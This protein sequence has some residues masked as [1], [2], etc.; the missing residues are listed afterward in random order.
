MRTRRIFV[1][2][3]I[4]TASAGGV[5]SRAEAQPASY[6]DLVPV[7]GHS[8]PYWE[9]FCEDLDAAGQP[10]PSPRPTWGDLAGTHWE[11]HADGS[12]G[13]RYPDYQKVSNNLKLIQTLQFLLSVLTNLT[14]KVEDAQEQID[15]LDFDGLTGFA[16]VPQAPG[17]CVCLH[18]DDCDPGEVL[19]QVDQ[20]LDDLLDAHNL[21]AA[22]DDFLTAQVDATITDLEGLEDYFEQLLAP[23]AGLEQDLTAAFY[24]GV[25][26]EI[27]ALIAQ[28]KP[29]AAA[30]CDLD[31]F[32]NYP[33]ELSAA[34]EAA[35]LEVRTRVEADVQTLEAAIQTAVTLPTA[36][37]QKVEDDLGELKALF[38]GVDGKDDL[39][40]LDFA[41][42]KAKLESMAAD[43]RQEVENVQGQIDAVKA[44]WDNAS[45]YTDLAG[46]LR[47]AVR[48]QLDGT[49]VGPCL[50]VLD[51]PGN[52]TLPSA[53]NLVEIGERMQA[54]FL[55]V[56]EQ[57]VGEARQRVEDVLQRL[58][59]R[60][61]GAPKAALDSLEKAAAS[62][63]FAGVSG[64]YLRG[65]RPECFDFC[66]TGADGFLW[67]PVD[68][69][70]D[71]KAQVA[72]ALEAG[73][74][75][76]KQAGWLDGIK[77]WID[78]DD[79][80]SGFRAQVSGGL[81]TALGVVADLK[82]AIEA[83]QKVLGETLEYV[84]RFMEGTHLGGYSV[85]RPDLHMCVPYAGHGPYARLGNLG[86]DRFSVGA[87]YTSHN[88]SHR[89]RAAFRS[90]GFAASALGRELSLLPAVEL[91]TQIHGFRLWD[92]RRPLGIPL[93]GTID[94]AT[95]EKLDVFNVVPPGKASL[96][97]PDGKLPLGSAIVRDLHPSK[98][99]PLA[100]ADWP[101]ADID[102]PWEDESTAVVSLGLN[103]DFDLPPLEWRLPP[104]V[105]IPPSVLTATPRFGFAA[106][107]D[108]THQS[109]LFRDRIEGM[110]N[111]N[112]PQDVQLDAQDF[113]REMHAFQAPDLSTDDRNSVYVE[114]SVGIDAF[115][116]FRVWKVS[117]GAGASADLAVN[118][119][120]GGQGGVL[121]LNSALS[122]AVAASNPPPEAVC[123]PRWHFEE[124][125]L[126]SNR[127]F[128]E[129]TG[130]YACEPLQG[131][132]SC[133][134]AA[135]W[136]GGRERICIDDW[137]GIDRARCGDLNR[138]LDAESMR[139]ALGGVPGFLS[140]ASERLIALAEQHDGLGLATT[141]N[142]DAT[143]AS[144]PCGQPEPAISTAGLNVAALSECQA[145]GYCTEP[146]GRIVHDMTLGE[147]E[148]PARYRQVAVGDGRF[149]RACALRASGKLDCW[150]WDLEPPPGPFT[151]VSTSR[152]QVC[153]LRPDGR[154][155]CWG[156]L[157]AD[158]SP[159]AGS[160]LAVSAGDEFSC[161]IRSDQK[162]TCWGQEMGT[163]PPTGTFSQV[164]VFHGTACA[165]ATDRRVHCWG[166]VDQSGPLA[167]SGPA[168]AVDVTEWPGVAVLL[169]NGRIE[170]RTF[171]SAIPCDL[172]VLGTLG[173]GP[174]VEI[175]V[176]SYCGLCAR[177]D[178]GSVS[179]R[180]VM[181]DGLDAPAPEVNLSSIAALPD[182][183]ALCGI[184]GDGVVTCWNGSGPPEVA[185]ARFTSYACRTEI[186]ETLQGWQG[187]GCHPLQH[188]FPS[189]CACTE[190]SQCAAGETC[191]LES[192][193]CG[194]PAGAEIACLAAA[195]G[196]CPA[197][198]T[199]LDGACTTSCAGDAECAG[200]A[201]CDGGLCRP[202][203]GVPFAEQIVWGMDYVPV[204]RH[205]INTYA[206]SDFEA[207][208]LLKAGV[209]VEASFKL[210]G[211]A[212]RW[213]LLDFADAWDLGSTYKGWYQ[214]GLSARY[215]H[216]CGAP[217][218]PWQVTNHFPASPTAEPG[219]HSATNAQG[220]DPTR[221]CGPLQ[222]G[223][224]CRYPEPPA[225]D[226]DDVARL[227]RWCRD[228]LPQHA[229][230][231]QAPS[232][233]DIAGGVVL[234]VEWGQEVGLDLWAENQ[235]CVGGRTW[236]EWLEGLAPTY[237]ADGTVLDRGSLDG[238]QCVYDDPKSGDPYQFE[239]SEL[240]ERMLAI[241]GCTDVGAPGAVHVASRPGVTTSWDPVAGRTVLDLDSIFRPVPE[242][243]PLVDDGGFPYTWENVRPEVRTLFVRLWLERL[244]FCFDRRFEDPAEVECVCHLDADCD[245]QGG[246][247]CRQG[248]CERPRLYDQEGECLRPGCQPVWQARECPIVRLRLDAGPCCGDGVV[249]QTETYREECDPE[250]EAEAEAGAGAGCDSRCRSMEPRGAC[251]LV[252]GLCLEDTPASDC[253]GGFHPGLS[254]A[255]VASCRTAG[256]PVT[257]ACCDPLAGCR[258]GVEAAG[259]RRGI[260]SPGLLCS[261]LGGCDA[262]VTG[263][264]CEG[265]GR[266][267]DGVAP[268]G[269]TDGAFYPGRECHELDGCRSIIGAGCTPAPPGM[270]A[271]WSFDDGEAPAVLERRS[272]A[273]GETVNGA[274]TVLGR[275]GSA[276]SLDGVDDHVAVPDHP[277]LAVGEGDFSIDL[278]LAADRQPGVRPIVDKRRASR[279]GG[280]GDSQL[281][282][283]AGTP[284]DR[285]RLPSPV[286]LGS[287][288][289]FELYLYAGRPGLQ[290]ADGGHTNF[291]SGVAIADGR[292][293]HLTVTVDRDDLQGIRWYLDGRPAGKPGNPT[294]RTGSL[295][296]DAP[297][298]IGTERVSPNWMRGRVD[299]L[300]IF[301]RV[302][303]PA[304]VAAI[305]D[306][307][308]AGKCRCAPPPRGPLG[309]WSFEGGGDEVGRDRVRGWAGRLE[310]AVRPTPGVVGQA[311]S[312][313][314]GRLEL[315]VGSGPDVAAGDL[316]IDAWIRTRSASG[317]ILDRRVREGSRFRG[318]S[319]FVHQGR[320]GLQLADG[321]WTNYVSTLA[322]ADGEWHHVAVT[323]DRDQVD[324]IRW[325]LD[326]EP[327]GPRLDPR[328]RSGS[329]ANPGPLRLGGRSFEAAGGW[330][331]DIDELEVA[332]RVLGPTEAWRIRAAGAAGKCTCPNPF[333]PL[334]RYTSR[335]PRPCA[336]R[337]IACRLLEEPFND[338]CG[339]GCIAIDLDVGK[340]EEGERGDRIPTASPFRG[341][342][343]TTCP[344]MVRPA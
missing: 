266:C 116:G 329:L 76:L 182:S 29:G 52:F 299:E 109:N 211:K 210:F 99:S 43:Y 308:G 330:R 170:L 60:I 269:C 30:A 19:D 101:R 239:C 265:P 331:G 121:D 46:T 79:P 274:A 3:A 192:G 77:E 86:G 246:E 194:D 159:P 291:D 82:E 75:A 4:V 238:A 320:L 161:G 129:S 89:H 218:L 85:L 53:Q 235:L 108:W 154:I 289:G 84:D 280:P 31:D 40:Q 315:P 122:D 226:A 20:L 152:F 139:D 88:L 278:W 34:V 255:E 217:D 165:V 298:L 249:Q 63:L 138:H 245:R 342:A 206:L 97:A 125:A 15:Q 275:V 1:S 102:Q 262:A 13:S 236:N 208:L 257:G 72:T 205:T 247:R 21:Q 123:E 202:P 12:Q 44:I 55:D 282:R 81:T 180:Q 8:E 94:M 186:A 314:G 288:R 241:W 190:D 319:L 240:A 228:D 143:C 22:L 229:E 183:A 178:D 272:G 271:W 111:V 155:E 147:C 200:T 325:Y 277:A 168:R 39:E 95:V 252:P 179:C 28:L 26:A 306:A 149:D 284:P 177:K 173:Q 162:L 103:L 96:P 237:A 153:A 344:V 91:T 341:R 10:L 104:I 132:S 174:W 338:E 118:L 42:V 263:A 120:P 212:K 216:E 281:L 151:M 232:N 90:G 142:G 17:H 98:P 324:G 25:D 222:G 264:C 213:R 196:S 9:G 66:A 307:R 100:A 193:R 333:D 317:T 297:L 157:P 248:R 302:L 268:G 250:A 56:L 70:Q 305:H 93:P 184:D 227:I 328:N 172:E 219:L 59:D 18:K 23:G 326:G 279:L 323:V 80:E 283:R 135:S 144:K 225:A 214:P 16:T 230:D 50:A 27:R 51:D 113:A 176:R 67:L 105:I 7:F 150:G 126:C 287:V 260:W 203:H 41:E 195:D 38:A 273:N 127:A 201:V 316:S 78:D 156:R 254:C 5:A 191:L 301:R 61:E 327:A 160:F 334:V 215:D 276:L 199:S 14:N 48:Q 251:C 197:G 62:T 318:Y 335:D 209:Y 198:R 45:Y 322:I 141:W 336:G 185:R 32:P 130:S 221:H 244:G 2:I 258:D 133:C 119:R 146:G 300:E 11:P 136:P 163:S 313:E 339:C 343:E 37:I 83:I 303:S 124:S 65:T 158:A 112:L 54:R 243:A 242:P 117:I 187:D 6:A 311:L 296:T 321:G 166:A 128:P 270:V 188:G 24:D 340:V 220:V 131:G 114:P 134:I 106:G 204:P 137:T 290:L 294:G 332:G 171:R 309:W 69:L 33:Q 256:G 253:R 164:D 181:P 115:L 49:S 231:P 293:H 107:T 68:F 92:Q 145:Y 207:T 261:D 73:K 267:R 286:L 259:C 189:A 285:S 140:K 234:T 337:R 110:V 175:A 304:E 292:W 312:F 169:E 87:R 310:G 36:T 224:V 74:F 47:D 71:P 223:G 35:A 64:C 58:E 295:T 57:E 167:L 148:E 233:D